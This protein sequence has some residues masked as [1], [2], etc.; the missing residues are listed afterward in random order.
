MDRMNRIDCSIWGILERSII[1]NVDHSTKMNVDH[2]ILE[3][4]ELL[5]LKIVDHSI[6]VQWIIPLTSIHLLQ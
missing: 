4:M 6:W 2:L 1:G 3:A 5:I